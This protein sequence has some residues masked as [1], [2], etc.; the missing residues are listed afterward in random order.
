V[1]GKAPVE[2]NWF[3]KFVGADKSV[4]RAL[5][6]KARTLAGIKGYITNLPGTSAEFVIGATTAPRDRALVPD[7]QQRLAAQPIYH[8]PWCD[9]GQKRECSLA[10]I[11]LSW[12]VRSSGG[13]V[14]GF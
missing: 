14:C 12:S 10:I 9:V 2:R 8:W 7:V 11:R 3:I 1:A 6:A 5:E 4:N 13:G